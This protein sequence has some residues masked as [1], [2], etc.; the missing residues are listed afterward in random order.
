MTTYKNVKPFLMAMLL[1]NA[2]QNAHSINVN[3]NNEEDIAGRAPIYHPL[4]PPGEMV[5]VQPI[6]IHPKIEITPFEV[7]NPARDEAIERAKRNIV[8]PIPIPVNVPIIRNL[9][10]EKVIIKEYH[11]VKKVI[12]KKK[13]IKKIVVNKTISNKIY[14][15]NRKELIIKRAIEAKNK[16]KSV[17]IKRQNMRINVS[18]RRHSHNALKRIWRKRKKIF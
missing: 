16:R 7:T 18:K 10:Q 8:T 13:V 2:H 6:V 1:V 5:E 9:P 12:N 11:P 3:N 4:T 14:Y 17:L 15:K